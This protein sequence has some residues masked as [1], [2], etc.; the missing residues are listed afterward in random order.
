MICLAAV[1]TAIYLPI[2]LYKGLRRVYETG[3]LMTALRFLVLLISY[4]IGLV[5][6]VAVAAFIAAFSV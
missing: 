3:H 4:F 5:A 2:Y 1:A 6:I